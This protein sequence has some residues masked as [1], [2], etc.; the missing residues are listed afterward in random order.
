MSSAEGTPEAESVGLLLFAHAADEELKNLV[1]PC[2]QRFSEFSTAESGAGPLSG[3][4]TVSA[5]CAA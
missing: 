4:A 3:A 5:D 2:L 1:L